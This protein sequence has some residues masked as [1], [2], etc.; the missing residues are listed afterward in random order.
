MKLARLRFAGPEPEPA[1]AVDDQWARLGALAP[2]LPDMGAALA[3]LDE[4]RKAVDAVDLAALAE[5]TDRV[6]ADGAPLA[7][8]LDRPG[9]IL[10]IG[11][12][13]LAHIEETNER[14]P[15]QPIL[16]GKFPSA[17]AGPHDDVVIDP[18]ITTQADYEVELA[19]VVGGPARGLRADDAMGA[20]A[21]YAVANDLSSRDL[22][23]REPQW[24]RSKSL[25]GFCPLGPWIT[26]ADEVADP[27][28]LDLGTSVNGEVRQAS[29]TGRMLFG[30]TD[31]L[32]FLS[33]GITLHP[34]DVVL[35]GTPEGV[36]AGMDD[37][38]WLQPGDVVRCHVE[39]L[40]HI[41][42]QMVAP[43]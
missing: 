18:A 14:R 1:V 41:E 24:I 22:Q 2:H 21:G 38:R 13:Y 20:V 11:R 29:N 43:A 33:Q 5:G 40:G 3:H 6:A 36:A 16:F 4:V 37:P 12:N 39:G 35:T 7:V 8:P 31:L 25:D 19:V 30:V 26:T 28:D 42:N 15:E 10:A 34:G 32:V 9:K 17:L 27:M 23:S